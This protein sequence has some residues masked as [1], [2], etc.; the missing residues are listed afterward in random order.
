MTDRQTEAQVVP[1]SRKRVRECEESAHFWVRELP[2]YADR[3]QLWA[4]SWSIAAGVLAALTSLSIFPVLSDDATD[5][6][7]FLVA[8]AAFAAAICALIPRVK[9]YAELA[10]QARELSSR[11][12]GVIGDLMDLAEANPFPAEAA[13]AVID[14]FESIK[15]RKDSLRGLPDRPKVN[16]RATEETIALL[17]PLPRSQGG[18]ATEP[19]G[20]AVGEPDADSKRSP[21]A[22]TA[23]ATA[24]PS[25]TAKAPVVGSGRAHRS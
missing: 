25:S 10:G 2:R 19:V 5:W 12:G 22:T 21:N 8:A 18:G 3:K 13:R 4:D 16:H 1:I 23:P 11:Y 24:S 6:Q 17:S 15:A 7:R 9:N 14:D 20:A